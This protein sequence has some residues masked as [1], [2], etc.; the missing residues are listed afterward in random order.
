MTRDIKK[1]PR[2]RKSRL[3]DFILP[4]LATLVK[5]P[6]SGDEWLHEL[7]FDGYRMLCR[8]DGGQVTLWSRNGKEWTEKFQN[9]IEAI[10]SLRVTGAIIDGEIVVVDAHGRSSFQK[11]QRAMGKSVTTGFTFEVFD[12]IYLDGFNLTQTPLKYRK[13][14]LK[15]LV[16]SNQRGI[17]RYS[18]DFQGKRAAFFKHACEYGIEGIVSKLADSPY[19]STRN[20]NWLKVKCT[21]QQEF[22]IAGYTPLR[23]V[24]PDSA[25]WFLPFTK[26]VSWFMPDEWAPAFPSSSAA[27]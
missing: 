5:E 20:R 18:E 7:K 8:I 17:I 26:R 22:V 23:K 11:L 24:Y 15:D 14:L 13:E 12:L 1:T 21:R 6:P 3:P 9:V 16:G 10:R 25:R 2:A 19:E 27:T 4:Q